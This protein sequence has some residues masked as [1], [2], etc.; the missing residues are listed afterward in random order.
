MLLPHLP[1]CVCTHTCM[2]GIS[3]KSHL[4]M[5]MAPTP[6]ASSEKANHFLTLSFASL[7]NSALRR[8][9]S[10]LV[11]LSGGKCGPQPRG[12]CRENVRT[13]HTHRV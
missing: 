6:R 8:I 12:Q 10:F 5:L 11:G 2:S 4:I 3:Q 9:M 13:P 1:V 7:I